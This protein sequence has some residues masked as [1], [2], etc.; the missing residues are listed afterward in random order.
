[1]RF[2]LENRVEKAQLGAFLMAMRLK[3]SSIDELT[4]FTREL[5]KASRE[6]HPEVEG[7]VSMSGAYDGK[8]RTLHLGTLSAIIACAA[9]ARVVRHGS[10]G[11]PP[12]KGV[13]T[14]DVLEALGVNTSM[15]PEE[16]EKALEKA[17]FAF[18]PTH[19][20]NKTLE[21][22]LMLSDI[23]GVRTVFHT[24]A[25][26]INPANAPSQ[27][28]GVAHWPFAEKLAGVLKNLGVKRALLFQGV[29]GSDE[30]PLRESI[31]MVELKEG[32]RRILTLTPEDLGITIQGDLWFEDATD[33][34]AAA[35][36]TMAVLRGEEQGAAR[37]AALLNASL[38]VYLSGKAASI[39]EALSRAT[40]A[41]DS[42]TALEKLRELRE[43]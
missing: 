3:G 26:L 37:T 12:K 19:A 31:R 1:M 10:T 21:D 32:E 36:K 6:I 22:L 17:G 9:G 33:A 41:L 20:F 40:R 14:L 39:D 2:I 15:T 25:P 24:L 8:T 38:A 11:V 13:G 42:G 29:E 18:L 5:K 27:F 16:A 30:L 23:L 35:A 43:L 34:R 7:L 28:L 4:A